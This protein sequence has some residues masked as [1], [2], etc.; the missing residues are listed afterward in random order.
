MRSGWRAGR[1]GDDGDYHGVCGNTSLRLCFR[2][3][4]CILGGYHVHGMWNSKIFG[5]AAGAS[6]EIRGVYVM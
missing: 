4:L 2:A 5:K 3:L 1:G 6:K